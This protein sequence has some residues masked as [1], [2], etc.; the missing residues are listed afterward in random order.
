MNSSKKQVFSSTFN[1]KSLQ[2]CKPTRGKINVTSEFSKIAV[3]AFKYV[4]FFTRLKMFSLF[5]I[6]LQVKKS[7]LRYRKWFFMCLI[8]WGVAVSLYTNMR[9]SLLKPL[10]TDALQLSFILDLH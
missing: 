6:H 7:Q 8:R 3:Y 10:T 1:L 2:A 4:S 9:E 5:L